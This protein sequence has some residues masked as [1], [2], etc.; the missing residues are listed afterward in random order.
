MSVDREEACAAVLV[1][2]WRQLMSKDKLLALFSLIA[3][4][5]IAPLAAQ[6]ALPAAV[7]AMLAPGPEESSL[8]ALEGTYDVTVTMW[9]QPDAQ[10]MVTSGIV[11]TRTM[12]GNYLQEIMRPAEGSEVPDF[13]RIDYLNFDRV[14][15]RWKYVSM[16]TRFP[17]SIM[18]AAS[19]AGAAADG[20]LLLQFEPQGFVGFGETVEGRFMLSDMKIGPLANGLTRKQQTFNFATGEGEPWV[21]VRYDYARRD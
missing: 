14:E 19:F 1:S 6:E 4:S 9:P 20:S 5:C 21:F 16:D 8:A 17:V 12:I 3:A 7:A 11:A 18:P 13:Q 15:G 2:K 10:P